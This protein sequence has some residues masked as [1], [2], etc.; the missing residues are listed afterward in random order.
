M[1]DKN[2]LAGGAIPQAGDKEVH[3][4]KPDRRKLTQHMNALIQ[5]RKKWETRWKAIRDYEMPYVGHFDDTED[6][7]NPARRRDSR[8]AEGAAWLAAQVFGAGVM[9]GLTPPSRQ[10]FK[11]S[12]A[13][14]TLND[15]VDC[16]RIL[17]DRQEIVQSV[18][19]KSNF[20]NSV[21]T[22]YL[23]LPFGQ[24]PLGIFMDRKHGVRFVPFTI[25]TYYLGVDGAGKV[26]TIAR[27]FRLSL[28]QLIDY[29]GKDN[30]PDTLKAMVDRGEAAYGKTWLVNW[31][32]EPNND[33]VPGKIDK[34]NMPYK[35]VYWLDG[36][37]ADQYLYLG[38]F[39]EFPCPVARYLVNGNDPYAKGPGWFAE[40]D[41]KALQVMK[42]DYLTALELSVKPP[43]QGTP[44]ATMMGINMIPGGFT[45]TQSGLTVQ[46]LF[47]VNTRLDFLS[48]EIQQTEERIK[49]A[50]NADLF[51]MLD[52]LG[53][54]QMTAQEVQARQAER[55]Q[56]LGPVVE[57]LQD[58]FLTLIIERVYNILDR[59]RVFPPIPD[60]MQ[61]LLNAEIKVEYISP[62]AQAQKMSGLVNIEQAVGFVMQMAQAWPESVKSIDVT[63][64]VSKYLEFL[65]APSQMRKS[66][67]EIQ[68][69][70]KQEREQMQAAQQEQQA[71][72]TAQ[73]LPGI[74]Q[75]AKNATDAANDGNPAL[76]EWLGM[77]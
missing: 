54:K 45:P 21:H 19:A 37:P 63:Q 71:Q 6:R 30:L 57:R 26:N 8:I 24:C 67:E 18:L 55:L 65:G 59:A 25:G 51:L 68:Q 3:N 69:E 17:D 58:E 52:Q 9:S 1:D 10:W 53:T 46:P 33:N 2:T 72:A 13:D 39:E 47:N 34:L 38:G 60:D 41:A 62:L 76:R 16:L 23:E 70:I 12:F 56:Q 28:N 29:F 31:I 73:A 15:R 49:R 66:P 7:T 64:T 44:D 43:M 4:N 27:R 22:V 32:C 77:N 11:L 74:T 61:D 40:G 20:Y 36:S 48:A 42:K 5:D 50:Y 75:A 14:S 35:S